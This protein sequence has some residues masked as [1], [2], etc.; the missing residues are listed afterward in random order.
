MMTKIIL[1]ILLLC[2]LVFGATEVTKISFKQSSIFD[3][4]DLLEIIHSEED[5][6]FEPRLLKLDK[7]LLSNFFQQQ[8]YLLAVVEDSLYFSRDRQELHIRYIIDVGPRYYYA[9]V[10]FQGVVEGDTI[11]GQLEQ[12]GITGAFT[13]TRSAEEAKKEEEKP[14]KPLPYNLGK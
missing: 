9:G 2:S 8:G 4:S 6:E 10:R 7:I 3:K 14:K 1:H 13:L 12:G 5:E 11:K